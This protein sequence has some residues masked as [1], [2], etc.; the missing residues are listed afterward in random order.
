MLGTVFACLVLASVISAAAGG[1]LPALSDAVLDGA[2]RAVTLTVSLCGMMSLWCGVMSLFRAA[3]LLERLAR[4]LCPL[5]AHVFPDA[6]RTGQGIEEIA[7]NIAANLLGIGNAATPFAIAAMEKMQSTNPDPSVASDDMV[8]LA[9]L[10]TASFSLLPSTLLALR[11]TSGSTHAAAVL[12]PVWAVSLAGALLSLFL[13][14]VLRHLFP[15]KTKI[16]DG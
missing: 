2:A 5:L 14:R 7:A 9:V 10:N 4:L 6:Q 15:R 16:K 13:A 1:C 8:T 3:G 11:R 12:L